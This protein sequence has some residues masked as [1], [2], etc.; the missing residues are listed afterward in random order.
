[1]SFVIFAEKALEA[2]T[3][4]SP[5]Q[6][7]GVSTQDS[8]NDLTVAVG[9]SVL[10]DT[11]RPIERIAVGSSDLAEATAM[12][13]TEVMLNGKAPGETTLIVWQTGGARQF[14]NV[15][16]HA[17]S[18][19]AND[20]MEALRRE[21]RTEFPGQTLHVS[22]ENGL[23]FL[24]GSVKDLNSSDRAV[25]IAS[26]AGKV[27]NLLFVDVPAPEPQILLKVRFASLDRSATKQLGINLFSTGA[28][29]S[30]GSVTTQQFSPPSV[31]LPAAGTPSAATLTNMLNLFIFRPDLNLGA[32][33]EA[34][35]TSGVVQILAEPNLLVA[36]GK[37][38]S[39]LAGGDFPYPVVQ[40]T[41]G[42]GG[43]GAV[44]IQFKEFGVRLNFIPTITPRGTIRLQVAPEVSSLDFANGVN[45]SGFTV[46]GLDVRRVKTEVELDEG[47]S[48][49]LGGL[50]DNRDTKNFSK[51]PF[52]G[53]IPVLG[54]FFQSVSITKSNTE[55]IVIV[56]PQIVYPIPVGAPL[57]QLKY[58]DKFMP[59]NSNM[60]MTT[61]GPEVTGA[62]PLAPRPPTIPVEK[63]VQSMQPEQPLVIDSNMSATGGSSSSQT[64]TSAVPAAPQ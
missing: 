48:F 22:S 40:G 4:D 58:P 33:I 9:K 19:V 59:S 11:A 35:Q 63:L 25:Q 42:A 26:T 27:V 36:N 62:K 3:S 6:A 34:L 47:Q 41:T 51:I 46:P 18:A 10:V 24:R 60:P 43:V 52:L 21:L 28:A 17:S 56:T 15:K 16:I 5:P 54:K 20:H 12:S 32:T 44:T 13:P 8:A 57:P 53:D 39:F 49:A 7:A 2:Q 64:G 55:L 1:L 30:I 61:P 45:I 14:F 37:Q 23:I 50:L 31:T 38:G 29:N